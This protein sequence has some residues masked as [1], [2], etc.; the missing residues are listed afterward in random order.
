[1]RKGDLVFCYLRPSDLSITMQSATGMY[2]SATEASYYPDVNLPYGD[3]PDYVPQR[4]PNIVHTLSY[5]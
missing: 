5:F 2:P 3:Y 4:N 1:M